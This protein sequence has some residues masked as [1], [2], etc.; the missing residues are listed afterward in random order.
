MISIYDAVCFLGKNLLI[1]ILVS[2]KRHSLCGF[3]ADATIVGINDNVFFFKLCAEML[4]YLN[5]VL[6]I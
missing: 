6:I 1:N 4:R 2:M 3:N 5:V